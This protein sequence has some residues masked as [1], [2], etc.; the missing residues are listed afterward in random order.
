MG[1]LSVSVVTNIIEGPFIVLLSFYT[2]VLGLNHKKHK[3]S[4]KTMRVYGNLSECDIYHDIIRLPEVCQ[5]ERICRS[6]E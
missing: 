2:Q 3:N 5:I 4:S 1:L 6:D